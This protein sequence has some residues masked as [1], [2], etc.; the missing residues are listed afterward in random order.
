[1]TPQGWVGVRLHR[2]SSV[3]D[4]DG[5]ENGLWIVDADKY[6]CCEGANVVQLG[7]SPGGLYRRRPW[8]LQ[9]LFPTA[10]TQYDADSDSIPPSRRVNVSANVRTKVQFHEIGRHRG[11]TVPVLGVRSLDGG[12]F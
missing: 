11:S 10:L 4:N 7:I 12:S 8:V 3:I 9:P 6:P 1:M 5:L 2:F